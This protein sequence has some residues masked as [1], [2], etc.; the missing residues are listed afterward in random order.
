M[1][2]DFLEFFG[3]AGR[4][5]SYF[6]SGDLLSGLRG[7]VKRPVVGLWLLMNR[8][9]IGKLLGGSVNVLLFVPKLMFLKII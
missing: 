2:I 4:R 6:G 8:V 3:I 1:F 5:F 7:Q 9:R